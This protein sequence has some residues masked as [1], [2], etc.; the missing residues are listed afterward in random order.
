MSLLIKN[1]RVIDPESN[2]NDIADVLVDNGKI[3]SVGKNIKQKSDKTIDANGLIVSPGFID[4]HVHLREPGEENKETIK[5]GIKAAEH[6]GFTSIACMPN[7]YPVNDNRSVTEY[8]IARAHEFNSVN[9]FPIASISKGLNGEFLS[10]M[11][12]LVDGGARGFSDDGKCVMKADLIRKALEYSKMFDVP[13]IEH[14]E[15]HSISEEGQVNEGIISY[16]YGLRGILNAAEEVIV[17]RDI[18]LQERIRSKLHL[19]HI[20]TKG[21]VDII[22]NAKK[23]GVKVTADATPHHILLT[24]ENITT[25][26]PAYKMKPPLRSEEDRLGLIEGIKD[27][28][29]DVIA[30]DHAPHTADEKDK[31]FEYAPFGVIGLETSFPVIYDRLVRTGIITIERMIEL[32]SVNPAKVLGLSKRGSLKTDNIADITIFDPEKK[33]EIRVEDFYSKASNSPFIGWKG[34]GQ[35]AYTI[36]KGI[37]V[38]KS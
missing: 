30:S 14:P 21:S 24:D 1:G 17:S 31:E 38:F 36:V 6:G 22:K 26:D 16:K 5:T 34:K 9:V 18:I 33:F 7:T 15:D 10:E 28:T 12:D 4:M 35:I 3:I 27:G 23:R 32:F 37:V 8:I 11:G 20:S 13:I 19:T 25:F 2:F 29:I